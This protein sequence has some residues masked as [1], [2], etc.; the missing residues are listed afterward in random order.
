MKKISKNF[1]TTALALLIVFTINAQSKID[2]NFSGIHK[3]DIS[4][5]SGDCIIKKGAGPDV[6][7][8]L[9]HN[10]GAGY[11][12]TIEKHG[13]KLVIEE[14]HKRGSWKGSAKW[15]ITVPDDMDIKFNT[16]SGSFEAS[17]LTL[18]LTMNTGSGSLTLE[19]MKGDISSNSGSGSLDLK[20]FSGEINANVGSGDLKLYNASGD[21]NL[22]CGSGSIRLSK[23]NAKVG[24]NVG[25]GNIEA[26]EVTLAGKSSFNSGSGDVEV[27]L[28]ASP[29]YNISVN[30]GSG[31]AKLDFNGN[32]IEGTV[33]MIANKKKGKISAPFKFDREEE[34]DDG[35]S[36]ENIKIRKTAV[37]GNSE[38]QIKVST[39]SGVAKAT[40]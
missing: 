13:N 39:G 6:N 34:V 1:L 16:G 11:D 23:V 26:E 14:K 12:P 37:F 33:V 15:T 31:D 19:N 9:D 25:S 20:N 32:A 30:S 5:S 27:T 2:K 17:D 24:A 18:E 7:V 38:V 29:K 3:I 8:Q 36:K 21:V 10:F 40:K 22:N 28:A 35:G 4:T